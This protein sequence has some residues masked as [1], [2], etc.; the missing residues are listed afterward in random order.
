MRKYLR[1]VREKFHPLF[2]ARKSTAGRH[3]IHL[4]DWPIWMRI[5]H[6]AFKVRGRM[7]THGL[8]F[9]VIGSQEK[10]PEALALACIRHLEI[11]SFWD[12][13]ANIGYYSWL[14]LSESPKL[15]VVLLEALPANADLI[16]ITLKRNAFANAKLIA[17][18]ASDQAGEG[19]LHADVEA[20]AT[21]SLEMQ[22]E[23]FEETHWGVKSHLLKIPLIAID[24]ERRHYGSIDFMKIDVEG[25]ESSVL[26]GALNTIS[27]DQPIIFIE[28]NHPGHPCLAPLEHHGYMLVDADRLS[29]QCDTST[30]N[31]YCFPKRVSDSVEELLTLA[32][33][34]AE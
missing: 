34:I 29:L 16:R 5:P 7:I 11:R 30:L 31:Y 17:A 32:R 15:E 12:V 20:G 1:L 14:A 22:W 3:L 6:V 19:I 24:D 10:N 8:A 2:Y 23:T 13:G 25:H 18:G 33:G 4:L 27:S 21:S 28:C 9:G 26:R